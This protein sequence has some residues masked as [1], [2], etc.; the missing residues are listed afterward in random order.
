MISS[1]DLTAAALALAEAS[2]HNAIAILTDHQAIH[3]HAER[4]LTALAERLLTEAAHQD[5]QS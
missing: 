2:R 1:P 5:A 3:T 4:Q